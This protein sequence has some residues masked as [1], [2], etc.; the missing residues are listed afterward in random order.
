MFLPAA[1]LEAGTVY[2]VPVNRKRIT[3]NFL[4]YLSMSEIQILYVLREKERIK[5][6]R[7]RGRGAAIC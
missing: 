3:V 2:C 6:D 1:R 4:V 5:A 7:S